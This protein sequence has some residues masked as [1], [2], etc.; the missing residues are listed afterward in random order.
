MGNIELNIPLK[1]E[2][3]FECIFHMRCALHVEAGKI[4][5][6]IYPTTFLEE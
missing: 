3:H 2:S 6:F 5:S 1:P 4:H